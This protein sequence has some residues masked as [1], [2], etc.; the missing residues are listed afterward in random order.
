[1]DEVTQLL[2]FFVS[3]CFG[4]FFHILTNFHFKITD[5]YSVLMRYIT[6]VLFVIDIV[7][8]YVLSLYYLNNGII[9]IY[10]LIFVFLGFFAYGF[11]HKNVNLNKVLPRKI[12]K[13]IYK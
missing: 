8:M 10:F 3:F 1:M 6:T 13:Y 11:L 5:T 12:A 7:L 9:H 4:F 2:S